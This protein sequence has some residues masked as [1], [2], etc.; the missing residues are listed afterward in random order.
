MTTKI[1]VAPQEGESAVVVHREQRDQL[2]PTWQRM[3]LTERVNP[4]HSVDFEISGNVRLVVEQ[5]SE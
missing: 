1:T 2:S 4:G 5:V 3:P